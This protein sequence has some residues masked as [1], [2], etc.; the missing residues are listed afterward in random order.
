MGYNNS[1]LFS[2]C[3]P[4]SLVPVLSSKSPVRNQMSRL[5]SCVLLRN[6]DTMSQPR[7]LVVCRVIL[8]SIRVG[9]LILGSFQERERLHNGRLLT[10]GPG[11]FFL[12]YRPRCHGMDHRGATPC[13]VSC[14]FS[15]MP[16]FLATKG[17]DGWPD[18]TDSDTG[19]K[20]NEPSFCEPPLRQPTRSNQQFKPT[21]HTPATNETTEKPKNVALRKNSCEQRVLWIKG[22]IDVLLMRVSS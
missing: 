13:F 7:L 19:K 10:L 6:V 11:V 1:C 8:M 20:P 17:G 2:V 3:L 16:A 5:L 12:G 22:F 15:P 21:H 14:R 18:A 9:R 4:F